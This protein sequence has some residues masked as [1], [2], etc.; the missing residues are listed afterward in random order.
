MSGRNHQGR[1]LLYR[2]TAAYRIDGRHGI[3]GEVAAF[4]DRPRVVSL[5]AY[6]PHGTKH[7][8]VIREDA[9]DV[10]AS[11][12]RRDDIPPAVWMARSAGSGPSLCGCR[13]VV[14][15]GELPVFFEELAAEVL[16]ATERPWV[17][18]IPRRPRL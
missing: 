10:V 15:R 3:V 6:R 12:D 8:G 7:N 16:Q 13:D 14:I 2:L 18:V 11:F 1:I 9:S 17:I 5:D 4:V